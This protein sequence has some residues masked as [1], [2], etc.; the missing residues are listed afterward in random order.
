MLVDSISSCT[1][2]ICNLGEIFGPIIAGLFTQY[3]GFS[4]GFG[5]M[6]GIILLFLVIYFGVAFKATPGKKIQSLECSL[7]AN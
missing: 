1:I 4:N 6:A 5:I 3:F 7:L 2:F